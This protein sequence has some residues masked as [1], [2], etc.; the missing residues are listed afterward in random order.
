[1]D[2]EMIEKLKKLSPD[3]AKDVVIKLLQWYIDE[4]LT[5]NK[6]NPLVQ[7]YRAK[8]M[9]AVETLRQG[10]SL[11]EAMP[12]VQFDDPHSTPNQ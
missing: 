7:R 4:R 8:L 9:A 2:K 6:D 3:K 12:L 5:P 11:S 10:G 1:V